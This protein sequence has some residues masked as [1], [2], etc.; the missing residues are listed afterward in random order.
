MTNME[1]QSVKLI[2]WDLD[3]TFWKG[4]ISEGKVSKIQKNINFILDSTD[5][6]IVHSICSKNDAIV[7]KQKLQEWA[8]WDYFVF[9]S[10]DWT[11]KG[12]RIKNIIKNMNLRAENVLFI[13]DNIQNLEE[14]KFYCPRL[15]TGQINGIDGFLIL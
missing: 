15:M 11:N 12:P 2:I 3:E 7:V 8:I 14:A 4:T 10:V 9:P 5:M 6:G 13:D 1:W